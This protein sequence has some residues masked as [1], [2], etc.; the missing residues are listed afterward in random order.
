MEMLTLFTLGPK[1]APAKTFAEHSPLPRELDEEACHET[2]L[3]LADHLEREG[4]LA[5]V[6]VALA[7][8][9]AAGG[10]GSVMLEELVVDD[11]RFPRSAQAVACVAKMLELPPLERPGGF[12]PRFLLEQF[13]GSSRS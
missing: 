2:E 6:Q 5:Q 8:C 7:L 12:W 1:S 10:R 9:D 13:V 11:Y 4:E 3:F